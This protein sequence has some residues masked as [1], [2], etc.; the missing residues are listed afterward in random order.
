MAKQMLFDEEA[1]HALKRGIDS[2]A[3]AVKITL[4]PRGRNVVLDKKF[5]APTI[6]NDGVT[7]AKDIELEDNFENIGAQLAKEIA[8]KTNDIAGDGTTTAT[9]LGQAIVQEAPEE[10]MLTLT[11]WPSSAARDRASKYCCH[12]EEQHQGHERNQMAQVAAIS[13]I[14]YSIGQTSS[15]NALRRSARTASSPSKSPR[16]RDRSRIRR[17]HAFDRGYI[18]PYFVTSTPERMEAV[19]EDPPISSSLTRSSA[20][21]RR[22]CPRSRSNILHYQEPPHHLR[23]PEGEALLPPSP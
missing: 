14:T 22:S 15:A 21:C 13:A 18:S 1:R 2:L 7:I 6:T 4:G 9:V 23:R 20:P 12:Q 11:P 19:I 10:R 5:G 3:D 16:I 17:R 8:S